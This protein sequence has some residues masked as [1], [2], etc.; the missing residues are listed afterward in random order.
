MK[1][2]LSATC[3]FLY[4]IAG[5]VYAT[6]NPNCVSFTLINGSD[7]YALYA[8]VIRPNPELISGGGKCAKAKNKSF[9]NSCE[10]TVQSNTSEIVVS[11]AG[12]SLTIALNS[13]AGKKIYC[14]IAKESKN[15]E[16]ISCKLLTKS[17]EG[18]SK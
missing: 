16:S 2:Y 14:D 13:F 12:N 3:L 9:V 5:S 11:A 18:S 8:S 15:K 17:T 10:M 4:L 6:S 7:K 1:K